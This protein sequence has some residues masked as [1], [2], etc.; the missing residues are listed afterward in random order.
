M[1]NKILRSEETKIEILGL[2]A[3]CHVWRKPG[4]THHLAN[5]ITT[6]KHGGGSIKLWGCFSA[7]GTGRLVRIEGK[8][9][10]AMFTKPAPM[11][12]DPSYKRFAKIV[13]HSPPFG[14]KYQENTIDSLLSATKNFG[15]GKELDRLSCKTCIIIGNGGILTNKSLGKKID[16]FDVVVRLNGAPLKGYEKDV[17]SKTTIRITYPE[18]A[19]QKMDYYESQSLFVLSAFKS[20]DLKWMRYMISNQKLSIHGA[21][22]LTDLEKVYDRVPREELWYCMRTSGVAE[23]YVRVVQDMY[24]SCKTVVRCAVVVTEEFKVEVGL[25]QGSALSPFLFALVMDRLTDERNTEGFWKSVAKRVPREASDMRIL[26][27]YF[28]Q[29]ASFKLIGL[30]YNNGQMGRGNVPTLGSVAI[31]MALHN[32]D[33]V[34]VAGFGYNLSTPHAPLHYYEKILMSA[35]KESWTHNIPKERA[36]LVKLVKAGV[37]QDLSNGI[38]GAGCS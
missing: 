19:F 13:D 9:N 38:C 14:V 28:I 16:E 1:R 3:K 30:P 34:A 37:I 15:L 10:A 2:N 27:P 6:V 18:G 12:L 26:N 4:T 17:G 20:L 23:K 21:G 8:M 22:A 25:H 35:I 11:F 5:T 33:E 36:F 24:E 31:T 32:C 29:E 7:A